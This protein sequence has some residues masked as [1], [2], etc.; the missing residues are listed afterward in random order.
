MGRG[1]RSSS[2]LSA[3]GKAGGK[4][5]GEHLGG[6][7]E[8][9]E[10]SNRRGRKAG[11][12]RSGRGL[13]R[14]ASR[15]AAPRCSQ[16]GRAPSPPGR[17]SPRSGSILRCRRRAP[18]PFALVS[19]FVPSRFCRRAK[20]VAEEE[21]DDESEKDKRVG[22]RKEEEDEATATNGMRC[23]RQQ[24]CGT[25]TGTRFLPPLGSSQQEA[26]EPEQDGEE[27]EGK[28]D[29]HNEAHLRPDAKACAGET[30]QV[31]CSKAFACCR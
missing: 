11:R 8:G 28:G 17:T 14:G 7:R 22:A 16:R 6:G 19:F 23:G 31:S 10:R 30:E 26:P 15:A 21:G 4:V 24:R 2:D 12:R 27:N 20:T 9:A 18:R 29:D 25:D 5:M 13:R 3:E 1:I